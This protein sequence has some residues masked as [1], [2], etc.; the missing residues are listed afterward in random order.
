M[1]RSGRFYAEIYG[2]SMNRGEAELFLREIEERG[3]IA[4]DDPKTADVSFL[5]TCTVIDTTERKM[6][7]AL[8]SIPGPL[9]VGGCMPTAQEEL[10]LRTRPDARLFDPEDYRQ[11][12]EES[13]DSIGS[14]NG[15]GP[16][17]DDRRERNVRR[18]PLGDDSVIIPIASGCDG[19]CSYCITRIARPELRSMSME[20]ISDLV[21][22]SG[23]AEVRLSA[24]DASAY[25]IDIGSDLPQLLERLSRGDGPML[26]VGMMNPHTL[27]PILD[28][29]VEAYDS[30]RV[31]KFLHL[32]LQS[33]SDRILNEMRREYSVSEFIEIVDMFRSRY[34]GMSISTDV[35]VGFPGETDA[36]FELTVAAIEELRPE[37]LNVTRFSPRPGTPAGDLI[38]VTGRI[39]K[40]RSRELTEMHRTMSA[41]RNEGRVG[42][43]A[44][45]IVTEPGRDGTSM[46]RDIDYR[47]YVIPGEH[48][49]GTWLNIVVTDSTEAY[50]IGGPEE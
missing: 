33:G 38:P 41:E 50:L 47:P 25:G 11:M 17:R 31:F 39:V 21:N 10:V 7:Q 40:E 18:H 34:P 15:H 32:P 43:R 19:Q 24:Q 48:N 6:L 26:R 13:L 49:I 5:F 1:S 22:G 12:L 28:R 9:Y 4:V 42:T 35:I 14:R 2:C 37:V 45:V 30:H 20:Q 16:V 8:G 29:T 27:L 3:L 36:D 46:A 23:K 44:E